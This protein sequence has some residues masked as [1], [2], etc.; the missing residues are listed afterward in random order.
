MAR[1]FFVVLLCLL[2]LGLAMPAGASS[3][4]ES[5]A[6]LNQLRAEYPELRFY[7]EGERITRIYG[8]PFS[9]G[10]SAQ[11]AADRFRISHS[12]AL[13]VAPDDLRPVSI[14]SDGRHTRPLMYNR[15]T[16]EYKFTLVYY[17][18][19]K[20][21]IP[22]YK[23]DLR[24]LVRNISGYPLVMAASALRDPGD[25]TVPSG[26][27][28]NSALAE[29]AARSFSSSLV[30]FTEPRLVIWAGI[31]DMI[32]ESALT[33]EIIADNGLPA[34]AEYEKWLLLVDA[35]SGE[36]LYSENMIIEID[37]TGNVSGM[38]TQGNG[39]DICGPEVLTPLPYARVYISGGNTAFADINGNF[40]IPHGGSSPCT[41]ISNIRGD[42]FR[43]YNQAGGDAQLSQSVTPPGPANFIHNEANTSEYNR[44]EVNAYYHANVVRD[45]TLTYH[46]TFPQIT[47]QHEWPV[48]VNLNDN[49]NAYYDYSSINFFTSGGGCPNTAFSTVVHH[50]YGHHLVAV[51]GSGQGAYGEGMGDV[52][53]VLIT[54]NAGLAYGFHGNCNVPLRSADNNMQYPC[55]GEIHYCGQLLSGCVWDTR[56]E[57]AITYPFTYRDII[58]SLVIN[59]IELHQGTSIT[60]QITIDFLELDD[61]DGNIFNGTP[62]YSEICA[63]FGAHNMD[64]PE[65]DLIGFNYP[66]GLPDRL[67]PLTSTTIRV[68]VYPVTGTPQPGTGMVYYD[69]GPGWISQAMEVVSPNVYD[70]VLPGFDCGVEID[71]YFSA[72][73]QQG[74][75][76]TDP[77]N[78]PATTFSV[79]SAMAFVTTFE[80]DFNADQGWTV[81]N[82][83]GLTTGQ[84]ERGVPINCNR[85]DPPADFDGSGICYLT[86]NSSADQCDSDVDDGY[87]YLISPAFDLSE[88]E[89]I[90]RYALWYTNNNGNDPNNDL[91]KVWVSSNNGASWTHVETFGPVTQAGWTE[92]SFV[93][94]DFIPPSNQVKVRFEA[95]DLND[96]SV[97][98]AGIDAVSIVSIEC[99][100]IPGGTI[101]GTVTD[102]N[103]SN[104]VS[105][106]LVF[107]DDGA[108]NTGSDVTIGDGSYS[109][110]LSPGTYTVSFTHNDYYDETVPGVAVTD[111]GN[112]LLDVEMEPLPQGEV[113]TLSEWGMII[114]A[115]LLIAVGTAAVIRRRSV[116]IEG[117][118]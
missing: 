80:D 37:V 12:L 53:G 91:F 3:S 89:Q 111:G 95:S 109:V 112:T 59:S 87:T 58:G 118:D 103:T 22:V 40:V 116:A 9:S 43:V 84:W 13:G 88:G 38:A 93:V 67:D 56:N 113:P 63:G 92:H 5:N 57:L 29:S 90:F 33:M 54:D 107:A 15:E 108:G 74:M 64:C 98:E 72:E 85:G 11:D 8:K 42:W 51:A 79:F 50:E 102:M 25:F 21:G 14:L 104:P 39:A 77:R 106:V 24:L 68:E 117:A 20:N 31:D 45:Y 75:I 18:Q 66:N 83:G 96:G 97:V 110:F 7:Q 100:P 41:V 47:G 65:L 73:E 27:T 10:S 105:G 32:V 17:S 46:P 94:S 101:Y 35:Q 23:A 82:S 6:A 1:Y 115:L 28:I 71:Y 70:A 44:A 36:I 114:M 26:V 49:C 61:D 69:D 60:P 2:T 4:D 86:H 30:N 48:N 19:F 62:H 99:E 76:V 34:T 52:M 81:Q 55:S 78:A 16:G